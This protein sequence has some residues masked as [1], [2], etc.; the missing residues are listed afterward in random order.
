MC[1]TRKKRVLDTDKWKSKN[2]NPLEE[3]CFHCLMQ[4]LYLILVSGCRKCTKTPKNLNCKVFSTIPNAKNA[5]KCIFKNVGFTL[6][7]WGKSRD[8]KVAGS[9]TGYLIKSFISFGNKDWVVNINEINIPS[10]FLFLFCS[11]FY[12]WLKKGEIRKF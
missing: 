3:N 7:L 1:N 10:N 6:K 12:Q 8:L 2:L 5:M 11:K 9:V 4:H